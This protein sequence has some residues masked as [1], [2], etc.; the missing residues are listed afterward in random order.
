MRYL[1]SSADQK[2][3]I[4]R[5]YIDGKL[6]PAET[7]PTTAAH[8]AGS[9]LIYNGTLYRATADIVI[10]DALTV[11]TNISATDLDEVASLL[12][13]ALSDKPNIDLGITGA[14][15]GQVATV[16]AVDDN[17]KPTAWSA[18][19]VVRSYTLTVTA[20][21]QD[22]VTVTGQTVTVRD[23]GAGGQV[24]ATAAYNGQPVSFSVPNGFSWYVEI[25]DT[26]PDH[27]ISGGVSGIISGASASATLVYRG[28]EIFGFHV[29]ASES[30]PSEAVT[31]LWDAVGKTPAHMDFAQ[32]VFNWGSWTANEFF[33][34]RPCMLKYDGTV[35]YYL[36]PTNYALREDGVTP[37]DIA[38]AGYAGNAMME[39]GR[40]GGKI[41]YKIVPDSG[42]SST[43][44]S[45]YISNK[46]ADEDYR[47]WSFVNMQGDLVDHF[48]TPIYNG[49]IIDSRLRSLSGKS[50]SQLCQSKTAA[51]EI[52]AAEANNPSTTKLWYTEVLA[53]I[54]LINLLLILIGKSLDTQAT[55][56]SGVQGKSDSASDMISTG[57]MNA[58]GLFWGAPDNYHGVKVF[59][60]E[61]WWGNQFRRYAGHIL[62]DYGHK[63]KYTY[64]VQDGSIASGYN[65]SGDGYLSAGVAPTSNGFVSAMRFDANGITTASVGGTSATYWCDFWYQASGTTYAARGGHAYTS[66][67]RGGAFCVALHVAAPSPWWA[68][69]AAPSCK[70]LLE[71]G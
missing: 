43:S 42:S 24:Y 16:S 25:T 14:S 56:G 51:Q 23:G 39:W 67:G 13:S 48:Y 31:Y 3:A 8:T 58:R 37:S 29:D 28:N 17:G 35:D 15:V 7:S 21:T 66:V 60:M 65:T 64:L 38:D 62:K 10:G 26:L 34:P 52:A 33:M 68:L 69:G 54:T 46:Q 57:T 18:A 19:D 12:K 11:G 50:Y 40:D 49:S 32:D 47:A 61:N 70:P 6:A 5:E 44:A 53:D 4:A 63:V 1:G 9:L 71:R 36:D 41:W 30:D 20:V 22:G 55:F 45:V 2:D 59:G 27:F